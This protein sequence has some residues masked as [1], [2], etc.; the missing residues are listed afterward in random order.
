MKTNRIILAM[1]LFLGTVV[2]AP[3]PEQ[4]RSSGSSG[5]DKSSNVNAGS[6]SN[7]TPIATN[8]AAELNGKTNSVGEE[9]YFK[10][11]IDSNDRAI[12]H[13]QSG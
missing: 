8:A 12:C 13:C 5:N 6:A 4:H 2:A 7:S 10:T 11:I 3:L 9:G 1:A